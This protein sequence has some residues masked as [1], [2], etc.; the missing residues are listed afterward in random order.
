MGEAP[1]PRQP[2]EGP[3]PAAFDR[4]GAPAPTGA[5]DRMLRV[6]TPA[7]ALVANFQRA[8]NPSSTLTALTPT[9]ATA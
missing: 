8:L 2:G 9:S 3:E 7:R 4:A 1:E 5:G 6:D